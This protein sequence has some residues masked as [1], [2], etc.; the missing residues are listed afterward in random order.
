MRQMLLMLLARHC[1][2]GKILGRAKAVA[3]PEN[4]FCQSTSC[5][6]KTKDI[7]HS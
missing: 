3:S 1:G 4:R 5:L 6:K 2:D 7:L